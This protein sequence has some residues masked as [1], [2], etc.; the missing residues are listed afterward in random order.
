MK[1]SLR[2]VHWGTFDLG[3]PR[4]R[5][6]RAGIVTSGGLLEDCHVPV[7]T[8]IEDK[9]VET[10]VLNRLRLLVRL[11]ASYPRLVWRFL[12]MP[13][14]DAIL[15]SFPGLLDTIAL[16]PFARLRGVPIV[17]DLFISAYDTL[18]FDRQTVPVDS[19]VARLL[20]RL[21]RFAILRA[22][23]VFMDT[24][25]HARRVE[26]L[27]QLHEGSCGAVLVGAE[28]ERFAP[29]FEALRPPR[30]PL[31]ILFYGQFIPLQGIET[32]VSAA[33]LMESE[34]VEW[35]IVGRGQ[36]APRIRRLLEQSPVAKLR[37]IDWIPYHEL[38]DLLATADLT[39]GIFGTSDKAA[40]VIPN[41]V[42]QTLAAGRPLVTRDSPAVRELLKHDPPCVYLIPAADPDSL[43]AAVRQH[44]AM[45]RSQP[46]SGCHAAT[47]ELISAQAIGQQFTTLLRERLPRLSQ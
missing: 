3:K 33:R 5:I 30:A 24:H 28:L 23:V 20:W 22:D 43:V 37:W 1:S 31:Q 13:R 9:T 32:I 21:E 11:A 46:T 25:A 7:W 19:W 44:S 36:E 12:R 47:R 18:V 38:G 17:L 2:V 15:I 14:P 16:A 4:I 6:L 8:G 26:Q 35:T 39:L 10:G 45:L 27:F 40:S 42:F 34:P 41:K 29:R